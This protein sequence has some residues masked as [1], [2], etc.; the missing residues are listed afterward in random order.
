MVFFSHHKWKRHR[1]SEY[2]CPYCHAFDC[3]LPGV[4]SGHVLDCRKDSDDDGA[5]ISCV[6]CQ[7]EIAAAEYESHVD[8]CD[9]ARG[10]STFS[11]V[12]PP[13]FGS[14]KKKAV[15]DLCGKVLSSESALK[16]HMAVHKEERPFA[17]D[18]CDF[19]AKLQI[20]LQK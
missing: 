5:H 4:I 2:S 3:H 6:V 10:H 18:Q 14:R 20:G 19:K 8:S 12:R 7:L 15:C 16:L 13:R 17:C 1:W 11:A 9:K